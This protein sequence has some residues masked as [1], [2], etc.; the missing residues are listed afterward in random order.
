MSFVFLLIFSHFISLANVFLGPSFAGSLG[1][2]P[3]PISIPEEALPQ[4]PKRK[5]A[6]LKCDVTALISYISSCGRKQDS[7]TPGCENL[8]PSAG[9]PAVQM[10]FMHD[11]HWWGLIVVVQG[12]TSRIPR[13]RFVRQKNNIDMASK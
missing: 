5:K 4:N 1:S 6:T 11:S 2:T 3:R 7:R 9:W 10:G 8:S 12:V 13:N